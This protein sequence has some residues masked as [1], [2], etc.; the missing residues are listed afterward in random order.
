MKNTE[1]VPVVGDFGGLTKGELVDVRVGMEEDKID[2]Q[3]QELKDELKRRKD[4]R[5]SIIKIWK[6]QIKKAKL[7]VMATKEYKAMAAAAKT[8]GIEILKIKDDSDEYNT[9][10]FTS[11]NFCLLTIKGMNGT[12]GKTK[13]SKTLIAEVKSLVIDDSND[14]EDDTI[15]DNK[16]YGRI[17][18]LEAEKNE[19]PAIERKIRRELVIRNLES[20][21][22]GKKLLASVRGMGISMKTVRAQ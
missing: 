20:S 1:I 18:K 10:H 7:K 8:L 13:M 16:I 6:D 19:L 9:R 4:H 5:D 3:I 14:I 12:V 15:D 2:L 21:P 11:G 22:K 17:R